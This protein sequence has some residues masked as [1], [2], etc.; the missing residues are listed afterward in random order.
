MQSTGA[1]MTALPLSLLR[2]VRAV[3]CTPCARRHAAA[4][5]LGRHSF[6]ALLAVAIPTVATSQSTRSIQGTVTWISD[7]AGLG[8]GLT[9]PFGVDDNGFIFVPVPAR[10]VVAVISPSGVLIDSLSAD[11][12]QDV[13]ERPTAAVVDRQNRVWIRMAGGAR[14]VVH[15]WRPPATLQNMPQ[16]FAVRMPARLV[17]TVLPNFDRHGNVVDRGL[18][19]DSSSAQ[20]VTM[21]WVVDTAS[22]V[23]DRRRIQDFR[24]DSA[25]PPVGVTTGDA[26]RPATRYYYQPFGASALAAEGP[27]GESVEAWSGA[28]EIRWYDASARLLRIISNAQRAPTLNPSERRVAESELARIA[29]GT[30]RRESDLPFGV[31]TKKPVLR[32]ISFDREGRLWVTRHVAS[33]SQIQSDV[34][35]RNGKLEYTAIWPVADDVMFFGGARGR[36]AWA[37]LRRGSTTSV[38]RIEFQCDRC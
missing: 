17:A 30:G 5:T 7:T 18:W 33:G 23:V 10:N 13:S 6:A 27:N 36:T 22:N 37:Y 28:Y 3:V 8:S 38:A 29:Q 34:Y 21:R 19:T 31:P 14:L 2:R 16:P 4:R 35:D 32:S 11:A 20:I 24:P 25:A 26:L 12:V 1:F 15:T 9:S